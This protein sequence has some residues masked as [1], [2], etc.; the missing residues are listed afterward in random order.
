[1]GKDGRWCHPG[2]TLPPLSCLP[3]TGKR[4]G[5][6]GGGGDRKPLRAILHKL[7]FKIETENLILQPIRTDTVVQFCDRGHAHKFQKHIL[8]FFFSLRN[9]FLKCEGKML[10]RREGPAKGFLVGKDVIVAP[11]P[12]EWLHTQDPQAWLLDPPG[13]AFPCK[14]KYLALVCDRKTKTLVTRERTLA[15]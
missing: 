4:A 1:M 13:S 11:G 9:T 15:K 6:G 5:T 10:P 7:R 14:L 2:L 8:F 12:M 3:S